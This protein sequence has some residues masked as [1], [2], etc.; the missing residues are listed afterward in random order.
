MTAVNCWRRDRSCVITPLQMHSN[1]PLNNPRSEPLDNHVAKRCA[2]PLSQSHRHC[3]RLRPLTSVQKVAAM[4]NN[5]SALAIARWWG[6]HYRRPGHRIY[7]VPNSIVS[8]TPP[9]IPQRVDSCQRHPLWPE[10]SR[11][12]RASSDAEITQLRTPAP[13]SP[14]RLPSPTD[15]TEETAHIQCDFTAAMVFLP[16]SHSPKS[17]DEPLL[18]RCLRAPSLT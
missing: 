16:A 11:M 15:A 14:D 3:R 6:G 8:Q 18:V 2:T 1:H 9:A 5:K 12:R 7:I 4:P 17:N 13:V 10:K